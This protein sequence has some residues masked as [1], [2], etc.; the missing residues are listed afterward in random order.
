VLAPLFHLVL[1]SAASAGGDTQPSRPF[2]AACLQ[3]IAGA[4][5]PPQLHNMRPAAR[6]TVH[7]LPRPTPLDGITSRQATD[8]WCHV[9]LTA[10][11]RTRKGL[12][13][14]PTPHVAS[15]DS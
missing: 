7:I 11:A 10:C 3:F 9:L 14:P 12:L 2:T 4:A 1:T 6:V 15:L 8:R 5:L 13:K